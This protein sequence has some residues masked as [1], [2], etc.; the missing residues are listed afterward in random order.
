MEKPLEPQSRLITIMRIS[1]AQFLLAVIF[2][3]FSYATEVSGQNLLEKKITLHI[4]DKPLKTIL[5]KIQRESGVNFMYSPQVTQS[6]RRTSVTVQDRPLREVLEMVLKPLHIYYRLSGNQIVLSQKQTTDLLNL[7]TNIK[8]LEINF[9]DRSVS[10]TISDESGM[11]LPGVSILLKGK[12]TGTTT[13]SEGRYKLSV[14]DSKS[15]LVFSFVGYLT[16]EIQVGT[17][18]VLDVKLAIDDKA[19]EEVVVVGY[20]TVNKRDLTG[21][22]SSVGAKQLKD[23]P[24][25]SASEALTGRLAGVQVT[26]TEGTPGA[27]VQIR[28][29]GG[30]SITQD[31]S[32]LYVIDGVQVENGLASLSPQDVESIDVLKDASATAIYGARGANGVVIV[33]TKGGREMKTTVNY[34]GFAG[35]RKISKKLDLM[36]PYDFIVYQYERTGNNDAFKGRY[37]STWDTLSRFQNTPAIDWQDKVFG[38]NAFSQTHNISVNG[39][40]KT[41]TY[42]LSVTKNTENGVMLISKFERN[43]VNFRFDHKVTSKLKVGFNVRYADQVTT[44]SG[45][46]A[47]GGSISRLRQTIKYIPFIQNEDVRIDQFD[48]EYFN[49]T[50]SG[51]NG[52]TLINPILLNEMEYKKN[53]SNTLNLNGSVNYNFTKGLSFRSNFGINR[54]SGE[55]KMFDDYRTPKGFYTYGGEPVVTLQTNKQSTINVS[56]VLAF[57]NAAKSIKGAKHHFDALIGQEIYQINVQSLENIVRNF[58]IGITAEKAL[59]QLSLGASLPLYPSSNEVES[60]ILSFFSRANYSFNDKYL[61]TFTVRADGSTKFAEGQRWGYFPSGSLAWRISEEAFMP[62]GNFLTDMKLRMSYGIAGNNRIGDFLYLTLFSANASPYGAGETLTPG[63]KV[64]TLANLNLKWEK[65]S[66]KN[67]GL[68]LGLWHNK[69]QVS[70]DAYQNDTDD[71]LLNVPIPSSSG[72]KTQLQNVGATRNRGIELQA[73]GNILATKN[74]TWTA[75][76]NASSNRNKIVKLSNYQNFYYQGSN[77]GISGQLADFIVQEGQPVGTMYG[78]V[79]EGMYGLDDFSYDASTKIYTLKDGV[80]NGNTILGLAQPGSLKLKDLNGDGKID[81]DNDRKIIGNPTPKLI[82]GLN[83]QFRYKNFDLSVF[84]NFV[85]GNDIMNANKIEFTNAYNTS[86]NMLAT[87]NDRW[88]TVDANGVI[89]QRTATVSGVQVVQGEAPAVLAELNKNAR[90]WQPLRSN[91]SFTLHSWAIEDGSFLRLSNVTLGYS[92]PSPLLKKIKISNLRF[93]VTGNNLAILT[94]YTG[95]DPEVSVRSS[96]PVTPG[97]DYSAYPRSKAFI[98]GLNLTF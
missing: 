75:N 81:A 60:R 39:G 43:L 20:G 79:T 70:L 17:R 7:D 92:L 26:T 3:S 11:G 13:D 82:G 91:G 19:L 86:A 68:D 54:N 69:L 41:T 51:G 94:R 73:T 9:A 59:A 61:A 76:F 28:I 42:N 95:Y 67:I 16:Q 4:E 87:M 22:V 52:L 55:I 88:R 25:N 15:V 84:L 56:N 33:T 2:V 58:P 6:E 49:E 89:V 57:N 30:G 66:S 38:R 85:I 48:E 34:N 12:Q 97:V 74:F 78:F 1:I 24:L 14:P 44:G 45:T 23:V 72:Y 77:W 46:S 83:Q 21:A 35:F 65:T 90:I 98:A 32:P 10:G 93:Y 31:N 53:Y 29:R 37:G 27:D 36:S 5:T 40:S 8:P 18:S 64:N 96:N 47:S 50:A 80:T 71:L 63:Y 62:K